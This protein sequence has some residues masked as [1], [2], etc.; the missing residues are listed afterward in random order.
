MSTLTSHRPAHGAVLYVSAIFLFSVMSAIVKGVSD[1]IP[2]GEAVFF[3]SFFAFPMILIPMLVR[4]ELPSG[5]KTDRPWDHVIRGVIGTTAKG[6]MFAGLG[7]ISLPEAT[8]ITFAAPL[9]VVILA[10]VILGEPIRMIRITAVAIGLVGVVIMIWPRLGAGGAAAEE[11][12][13][14][15][16]LCVLGATLTRAY[17]Q[18]HVR[19]MVAREKPSTIVFYFTL[20]S[21]LAALCT[22]PFGWVVPDGHTLV[23]LILTGLIGGVGQIM[24]TA[25]YR[26]APA[27]FLAP[28]DYSSM[29]FAV[30]IGYV[31]FSEVPTG[32]VLAGA[33]LVIAGNALVIWR[34]RQLGL[35]RARQRGIVDQ[36]G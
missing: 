25:S 17:V 2:P 3:R 8:A 7:M 27:S 6:L 4:G 14:I 16:A 32:M 35:A 23:L 15:G 30:V 26:Y 28:Y 34:E 18:I 20:T 11:M 33:A 5:L 22:L 21:T 36:K 1:T 12:A 9:F 19:R 31:W 13:A 24:V 29:L 10:V